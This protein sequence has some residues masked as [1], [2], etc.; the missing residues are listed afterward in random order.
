MY[1]KLC[2]MVSLFQC[3]SLTGRQTLPDSRSPWGGSCTVPIR[4]APHCSPSAG[5]PDTC[6]HSVPAHKQH[7]TRCVLQAAG[8]GI[9]SNR[10]TCPNASTFSVGMNMSGFTFCRYH[11][12][13]LQLNLFLKVSR[14]VRSPISRP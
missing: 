13:D 14:S 2:M 11:L 4:T 9:M 7:N 6:V 8:L 1:N 3:I 5:Y 10:H 12:N